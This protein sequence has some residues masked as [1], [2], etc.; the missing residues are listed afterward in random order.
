MDAVKKG[1]LDKIRACLASGVDVNTRNQAGSTALML[2][3]IKENAAA[4]ELLLEKRADPSLAN[5]K[6]VSALGLAATLSLEE[7]SDILDRATSP[8]KKVVVSFFDVDRV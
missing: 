1:D 2:A 7:I 3:I 5:K 6:G 8:P 4:V